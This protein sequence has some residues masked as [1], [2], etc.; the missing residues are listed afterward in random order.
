MHQFVSAYRASDEI[1]RQYPA[2]GDKWE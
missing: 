2:E 1:M